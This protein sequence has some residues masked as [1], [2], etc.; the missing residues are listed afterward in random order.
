MAIGPDLVELQR[1]HRALEG[2]PLGARLEPRPELSFVSITEASEYLADDG[3][4]RI[5]RCA[6]RACTRAI[7]R[8]GG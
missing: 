6:T 1:L 2:T 5:R 7:C 4:E 8:C 3:S